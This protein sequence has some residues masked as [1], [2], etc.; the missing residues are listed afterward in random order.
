MARR[1]GGGDLDTLSYLSPSRFF[2]FPQPFFSNA[3]EDSSPWGNGC[4]RFHLFRQE[5]KKKKGEGKEKKRGKLA[6]R[7]AV[8]RINPSK[9]CVKSQRLL[10]GFPP[11]TE[12]TLITGRS[13]TCPVVGWKV[14]RICSFAKTKQTSQV[15]SFE[16]IN[17]PFV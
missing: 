15:T 11:V 14:A 17:G 5:K 2:F 7:S 9:G 3:S 8:G 10:F 4:L 1:R 16:C 13:S 12:P 6:G